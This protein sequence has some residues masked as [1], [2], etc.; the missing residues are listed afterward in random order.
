MTTPF[1]PPPPP[2]PTRARSWVL[3][4][5]ILLLVFGLTVVVLIQAYLESWTIQ[6]PEEDPYE[7]DRVWA[8][9]G[10]LITQHEGT[11][12]VLD[13]HCTATRTD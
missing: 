7:V 13:P 11:L 2:E 12:T 6:C 9:G 3:S 1:A 4:Y 5:V 10:T 8:N